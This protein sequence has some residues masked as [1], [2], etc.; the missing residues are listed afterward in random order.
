MSRGF[1]RDFFLEIQKGNI[2]KH[3]AVI[4]FGR[5]ESVGTT[6]EPICEGSV[7]SYD[8]YPTAAVAVRIFGAVDAVNDRNLPIEVFGLDGTGA[9]QSETI[10]LDASDSSTFVALAN[11]YWRIVRLINHG[12]TDNVQIITAEATSTGSGVTSGDD[13]ALIAVGA[14]Q[15]NMCIY[16]IP[17]GKTGFMT[18]WSASTDRGTGNPKSI[19]MELRVR[20]NSSVSVGETFQIKDH[21]GLVVGGSSH[22]SHPYPL[23]FVMS[24]LSD[25]Q[26]RGQTD[27]GTADV[28]G[29]F[30]IILVDD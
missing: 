27:T 7:T 1:S 15:T 9:L 26:M 3:S 25:I 17:V 4:K 23:P 29:N 11:T 19:D 30:D 10:N 21:Q 12:T 24:A 13:A 20:P 18:R 28:H 2:A 14:N 16:T 8:F 6:Q 5:N 22:F